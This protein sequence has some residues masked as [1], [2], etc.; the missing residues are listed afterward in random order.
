MK[1]IYLLLALFIFSNC[2]KEEGYGPYNLKDEQEVELLV[3][4]RYGAIDDIPLLLPQKE[5]PQIPLSGFSEREVGYI[6]HIKA[7]MA[8]Y[9][10]QMMD[11]GSMGHLQF[12]E[13]ISKKKSDEINPFE[14]SL[15]RQI[16]PGP[17]MIYLRKEED[18]Y[19]HILQSGTQIQLTYDDPQVGET[20]EEIWKHIMEIRAGYTA[21]IP[22]DIKWKSIRATVTHDADK[23]GKA[24]LVSHIELKQ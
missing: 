2:S 9:K 7:K 24:Y 4:D 8:A 3:G 15:V 1:Y 12:I 6:Y 23:F 16:V 5:S 18:K 10:S 19:L 22:K 20:L 11:G 14:L 21:G 17:A 13:V